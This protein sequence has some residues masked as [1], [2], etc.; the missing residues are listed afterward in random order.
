MRCPICN[1]SVRRNSNNTYK[2]LLTIKDVFCPF[3][4]NTGQYYIP[5]QPKIEHM[6]VLVACE[7][8]GIV[9]DAFIRRGHNAI[10][11]DLQPTEVSGPHYQGDIRDILYSQK[12]DLLIAHPPCTHLAGSGAA[13]FYYKK[14]L[15]IEALEFVQMFLDAP[16]D[17]ICI[18]NPVG[19]IST[20]LE[21]PTQIIEPFH[22]GEG[23]SK[24]TCLWLKGLPPLKATCVLPFYRELE[25]VMH[26]AKDK[27][28][29][30]KGIAEAMAN[31]WG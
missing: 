13:W 16:V 2:P 17:R 24:A 19:I 6:N 3:C 14:Q 22:F 20:R 27:S 7:C 25:H 9:R 18:E 4:Y 29:T 28:R 21:K 11:C 30:F 26:T 12:W 23:I 10:S 15:Q 1:S 8:S 31:Q 5:P